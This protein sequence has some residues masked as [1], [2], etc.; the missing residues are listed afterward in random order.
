MAN[1]RIYP[2]PPFKKYVKTETGVILESDGKYIVP[3]S[4][5]KNGCPIVRWGYDITYSRHGRDMII[6]FGERIVAT[7]DTK[8][9]LEND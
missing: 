9:E 6:T 4:F 7:A 3:H 2:K 8:E 5:S 1:Q